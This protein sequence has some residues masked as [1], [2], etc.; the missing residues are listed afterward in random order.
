[1]KF[2]IELH[3]GTCVR[4]FCKY[5]KDNFQFAVFET[6]IKLVLDIKKLMLSAHLGGA[7]GSERAIKA[8]FGQN[9]SSY[10]C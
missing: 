9:L 6:N 1:M 3:T 2:V 10:T 4:R 8:I 5:E 7:L